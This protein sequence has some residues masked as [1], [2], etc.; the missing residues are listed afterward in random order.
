[1]HR[2]QLGIVVGVVIESP[3]IDNS[4]ATV[5]LVDIVIVQCSQ[6]EARPARG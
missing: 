6:A 2:V 1:M 3:W 5:L 4:R